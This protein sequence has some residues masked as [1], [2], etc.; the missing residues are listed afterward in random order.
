MTPRPILRP[1]IALVAAAGLNACGMIESDPNRFENLANSVA[2]IDVD[3][4][5]PAAAAP[6]RTAADS[7]L[8]PA[9]R[10]EVMDPHALWDARDGLDGAVQRAAPR[11]AAAAAPAVADA[12]VRQ[13]TDR[14][15]AA[16]ARAGLRPALSP[17][18]APRASGGLVQLGAYSSDASA[19]S[20]WSRLKSGEAAAALNG[21]TPVYEAVEVGGRR[22]VRLKVAAPAA[23]A[24]AICAAADIDD[25]WCNRVA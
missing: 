4:R 24:A 10:V 9:L 22:L 3:G 11:I 12:V 17:R 5:A 1:V 13:V 21:L 23:G 15:D 6:H 20:A 7:G 2:A 8:R 19:R 25:P 16:S 14:V 18:P